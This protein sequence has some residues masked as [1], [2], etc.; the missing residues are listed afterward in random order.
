[1]QCAYAKRRVRVPMGGSLLLRMT[2]IVSVDVN[3]AISVVFVFV[4]VDVILQR[5]FQRPKTDAKQHH[6][7][8]SFTPS[9]N[10]FDGDH[11]LQR[12]QQQSHECDA[13]RMTQAP[14][15]SR[16]PRSARTPHRQRCDRRQMIRPRPD[17][18]RPGDESRECCDDDG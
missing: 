14:S 13:R 12:E 8:E 7:H 1:M 6:A 15:R 9:G 2:V 5:K 4:R 11:V 17:M 18:H 16:Q 3:M 10:P